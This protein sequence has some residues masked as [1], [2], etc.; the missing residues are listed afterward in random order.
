MIDLSLKRIALITVLSRK[1]NL[2]I[3][4]SIDKLGGYF[5]SPDKR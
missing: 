5:S 2:T 3:G 4:I 1:D